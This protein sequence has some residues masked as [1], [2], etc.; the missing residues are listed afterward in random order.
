MAESE[1][2]MVSEWMSNGNINQF[3]EKHRDVNR[4]ELVGFLSNLLQIL[5]TADIITQ[6]GD[7]AKGLSYMHDEG[8]IHGDLKPVSLVKL[9]HDFF[10][11]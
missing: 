11:G 4:F 9:K 5:V 8:M 2:A 10:P 1:F 6:L 7:V 3:V